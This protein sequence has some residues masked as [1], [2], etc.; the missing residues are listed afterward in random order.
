MFY[1]TNIFIYLFL[2]GARE[3]VIQN[4]ANDLLIKLDPKYTIS[5]LFGK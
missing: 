4:L 3:N 5:S 1:I 2:N